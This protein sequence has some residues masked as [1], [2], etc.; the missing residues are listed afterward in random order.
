[1][2]E[3][4]VKSLSQK[5]TFEEVEDAGVDFT[6][7]SKREQRRKTGTARARGKEVGKHENEGELIGMIKE[8]WLLP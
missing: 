1:M 4:L 6:S 2:R 8:I 7:D 5:R 3:T